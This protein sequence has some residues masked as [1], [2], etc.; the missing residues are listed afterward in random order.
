VL[1]LQ[2]AAGN[3]AVTHLLR[4]P[5]TATK[6]AHEVPWRGEVSATW[7]A[8]LRRAPVKDADHPYDNI[9]ADLPKGTSVTVVGEERGWLHAEVVVDGKKLTGYIS[10]E[11]VR[12]TGPVITPPTEPAGPL[13]ID[14]GLFG[15]RAAFVALKQAENRRLAVPDW[16]P[17]ADEQRDLDR[18]TDT[19]EAT[20]RY[21]VDHTTFAVTFLQGGGK[22]KVESIEDFVLF[23]ETVEKQYPQATPREIAGEVRQIWFGGANW[24]ALLNS[25]GVTVGGKAVDIEHEPDPIAQI[26]DIPSLKSTGHKLATGF[27]DVDISH[28]VAGIDA[29]LSG[30]AVEPGDPDSD[31]HLKW[32]TLSTAD[33]GDPRDFVT[34]S[35]DLGQAYAEYLAARYVDGK[36]GRL[37][38][39]VES[40]ASAEQLLGDIHGYI[41]VQVFRDTPMNVGTGWWREGQGATVSNILRT[42]YM[43]E[44]TGSA[45]AGTYEN[46]VE[47]VSGKSGAEM[48]EFVLDRSLAFARPW[49]AKVAEGSRGGVTSWLHDPSV[50]KEGILS[51]LMVEFDQQHAK[52]ERDADE[53]DRLGT[54][55]D[56]FLPMLSG[57]VR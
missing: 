16:T 19:L 33:T 45:G 22:I 50:S 57:G 48:R 44:K 4:S 38:A 53:I 54:V 25:P 29:A 30:A 40:K 17:T 9:L 8:A 51:G 26:F 27:G 35:G 46:S 3:R 15:T 1:R 12:F 7:N 21:A 31:A 5:Q 52:N 2:R 20:G 6:T 23:V 49:Y 36:R 43:V 13:V 47:K 37:L 55:I 56:R 28:V 24:E 32:Q 42:F 39:Y 11:L 18:A 41:A 10:H 14:M 34:W